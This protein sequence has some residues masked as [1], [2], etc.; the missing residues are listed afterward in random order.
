LRVCREE[1]RARLIEESVMPRAAARVGWWEQFTDM[2]TGRRADVDSG[3]AGRGGFIWKPR[4]RLV[5]SRSDFL[6]RG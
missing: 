3:F 4:R 1:L 5:S 2:L 6:P